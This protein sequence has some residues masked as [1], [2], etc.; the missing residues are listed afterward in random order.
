M[1]VAHYCFL[2]LTL[3]F[4]KIVHMCIFHSLLYFARIL[5]LQNLNH[6]QK[7]EILHLYMRVRDLDYVVNKLT[8]RWVTWCAEKLAHKCYEIIRKTILWLYGS[9]DFSQFINFYRL[10]VSRT[11]KTRKTVKMPSLFVSL[12][13]KIS[14]N[15]GVVQEFQE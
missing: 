9:F 1:N 12:I 14:K 6:R 7:N 15:Q 8:V 3:L 10:Q 13:K 2:L 4:F 5:F 11:L